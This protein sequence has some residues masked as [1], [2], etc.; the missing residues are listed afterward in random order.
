MA[1]I[2]LSMAARTVGSDKASGRTSFLALGE[3]Q[4]VSA[5][6]GEANDEVRWMSSWLATVCSL[7]VIHSEASACPATYSWMLSFPF[8]DDD[9]KV[10]A[11]SSG[12]EVA[13]HD[14]ATPFNNLPC[15]F[16]LVSFLL[17]DYYQLT[18][19]VFLLIK[20]TLI[21]SGS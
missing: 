15:L 10:V 4:Y 12:D 1:L 18:V 20:T 21:S 3:S 2:L 7:S 6:C 8:A 17:L 19:L 14:G 5:R 9:A 11:L 13:S 16:V